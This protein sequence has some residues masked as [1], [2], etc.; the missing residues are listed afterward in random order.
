MQY[1]F[2]QI[3]CTLIINF[4]KYAMYMMNIEKRRNNVYLPESQTISAA[5]VLRFPDEK[6][7]ILPAKYNILLNVPLENFSG[8]WRRHH[9]DES[10]LISACGLWERRDLYRATLAGASIL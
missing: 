3:Q 6:S 1:L 10:F 8:I 4:S 2:L 9:A 7:N 5:V